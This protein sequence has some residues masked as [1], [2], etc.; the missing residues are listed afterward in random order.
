MPRSLPEKI[1]E[2]KLT[3]YLKNHTAAFAFL[4]STL[5][6]KIVLNFDDK[7][8]DQSL[9]DFQTGIGAASHV[10]LETHFSYQ[11]YYN[12]YHHLQSGF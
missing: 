2:S 9:L 11:N 5:L 12:G 3:S 10:T 6:D 4:F 1:P 7:K 8:T